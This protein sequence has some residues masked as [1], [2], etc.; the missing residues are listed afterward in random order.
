MRLTRDV[1]FD[2]AIR[3]QPEVVGNSS[4]MRNRV[5][6]ARVHSEPRLREYMRS[7]I[8]Y[9]Q[10]WEHLPGQTVPTESTQQLSRLATI[11]VLSRQRADRKFMFHMRTNLEYSAKGRHPHGYNHLLLHRNLPVLLSHSSAVLPVL[12]LGSLDALI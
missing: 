5:A 4:K 11:K 1:E 3:L 2:A 9:R 12:L 8:E 6:E 10:F 7:T